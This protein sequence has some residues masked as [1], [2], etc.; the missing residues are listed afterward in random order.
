MTTP[1]LTAA[2]L[3]AWRESLGLNMTQAAKA[4]GVSDGTFRHWHLP[5]TSR[6]FRRPQRQARVTCDLVTFIAERGW[7]E[8]WLASRGIER[9]GK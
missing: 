6:S 8:H 3:T 9:K 1:P 5:E 7:L 4:I 2:E